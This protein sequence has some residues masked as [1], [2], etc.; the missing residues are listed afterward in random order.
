MKINV[1]LDLDNTL[2]SSLSQEEQRDAAISSSTNNALS[3]KMQKLKFKDMPPDDEYKV[4]ER[5]GLQDFLDF[6]FANFNV[7]VWTAASKS[8]ALFIIDYFVIADRPERKIDYVFFSHHCRISTQKMHSQK[9]LAMLKEFGVHYDMSRTYIIDDHPEVYDAQPKKCI[10]VEAFEA[11]A[12]RSEN[13]KELMTKVRKRLS[14][15][16]NVHRRINF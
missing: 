10:R 8:Y 11:L 15:I 13:D 5:P 3:E 4:F 12:P 6:L 14:R 1:I 2:I 16:L 7:S 9:D